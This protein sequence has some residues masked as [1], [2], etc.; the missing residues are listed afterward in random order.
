MCLFRTHLALYEK[1]IVFSFSAYFSLHNILNHYVFYRHI[2]SNNIL[3]EV[4]KKDK[5]KREGIT[6]LSAEDCIVTVY[7]M[8]GSHKR[9]SHYNMNAVSYTHLTLP[10]I[11]SV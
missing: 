10:T 3:S 8:N 4:K 9:H 6:N 5:R 11:C 1:N 2:S 7:L